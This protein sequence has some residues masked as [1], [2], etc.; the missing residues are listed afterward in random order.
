MRREQRLAAYRWR[1]HRV[2]AGQE[3]RPNDGAFD[4]SKLAADVDCRGQCAC[5]GVVVAAV[6][7]AV[8]LHRAGVVI[9]RRLADDMPMH[10]PVI[11]TGVHVRVRQQTHQRDRES[12]HGRGD[13]R[14][15][16]KIH[17]VASMSALAGQS[18][19]TAEPEARRV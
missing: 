13:A 19:F 9:G 4:T 15:Q 16:S 10:H 11:A 12:G 14:G 5:I 6:P 8:V 18:Q 7:A 17:D 3:P 2:R 1:L